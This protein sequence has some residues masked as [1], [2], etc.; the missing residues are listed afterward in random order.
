MQGHR[1]S[2]SALRPRTRAKCGL[3]FHSPAC[4]SLRV[5][6]R[7]TLQLLWPVRTLRELGTCSVFEL[8]HKW[9]AGLCTFVSC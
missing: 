4:C 5:N 3:D 9:C 2:P 1:W 6:P 8:H 7:G